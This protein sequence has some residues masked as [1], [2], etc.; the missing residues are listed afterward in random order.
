VAVIAT[1][2]LAYHY[3][4]LTLVHGLALQTPLAY[5]ALVPPIALVLVVARA[6]MPNHE[7]DIHDRYLDY[8][9][10]IPLLI[11]S[12]TAVVALPVRYSSFYWLW[13]IDLL[14]FPLFVAGAVS[15]VFGLR[16]LWR[17]RLAIAF[18][19]LAW[20]LPY[21]LI[22]NGGFNAVTTVTLAVLRAVLRVLPLAQPVASPDGS[23]FSIS[24]GGGQFQ[25][26]VSSACSGVNGM[27]GFALVG[28]AFASIVRGR[29]AAKLLWLTAGLV[30]IW[31][32]DIARILVI[33]AAGASWGQALALNVLH[34]LVG[35][36]VFNLG[37]LAMIALLRPFKLRLWLPSLQRPAKKPAVKRAAVALVI[38][39]ITG[40]CSAVA[41]SRM[42][43]YELLAQDLGPPRLTALSVAT[44]Q[45]P[46]WL[47]QQTDNYSWVSRYF[48][49]GATWD[50]FLFARPDTTPVAA[51][52]LPLLAPV[53]LDVIST[54]DLKTFSAYGLEACYRFHDYRIIEARRVDLGAG[55]IGHTIVASTGAMAATWTA[56]YWEWPVS[57]PAGG[58]RYERVVLNL[59]EPSGLSPQA[60]PSPA[61][62]VLGQLQFAL[63][64]ALGGSHGASSGSDARVRNFLVGFAHQI[65]AATAAQSATASAWH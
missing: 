23:L 5:L 36:L 15:L 47:Q 18:L 56:V 19:F 28:L 51:S 3:S 12:L 10:G 13:R 34:P 55:V 64:D 49:S 45:L 31:A 62:G 42:Q 39:G 32:L 26:T 60:T 35:L 48:G 2:A 38:V 57:L 43:H 40:V 11:A 8:M 33:F 30:L 20:P 37:I 53:T 25:V 4:L 52:D 16:A 63:A 14:A 59:T 44:V 41:D 6:A 24:H 54:R 65:V 22:F 61:A 27:V 50:R 46:G 7:P 17:Q 9:I 1:A 29:L 21:L 58:D